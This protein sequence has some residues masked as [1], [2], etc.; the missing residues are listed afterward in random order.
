MRTH[1]KQKGLTLVEVLAATALLGSL[2]VA[3]LITSGRAKIQTATAQ[4]RIEAVEILDDLLENWWKQPDRIQPTADGAV[5]GRPGWQWRTSVVASE[6]AA[7]IE[8]QFVRVEIFRSAETTDSP[9]A[10]A[11]ILL[12]IRRDEEPEEAKP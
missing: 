11:E 2:L 8:G 5:P 1:S 6:S 10:S 7:A 9:D 12:P 3:T 4:R